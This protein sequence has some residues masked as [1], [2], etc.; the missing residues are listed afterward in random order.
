MSYDHWKTT[1]PEDEWLGPD[2]TLEDDG[3]P[4]EEIERYFVSQYTDGPS[5]VWNVID[6][7]TQEWVRRFPTEADAQR[8]A[9]QQNERST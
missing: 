4:Q 2:P 3:E 8:Y 5:T 7:Q 1:N 6:R 9:N